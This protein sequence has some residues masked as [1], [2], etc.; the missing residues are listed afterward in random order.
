MRVLIY[1]INYSPELTG[2]GKYSGEMAEWLSSNGHEVVVV[3]APPYYPN[4]KVWDGYR[5]LGYSRELSS[6][7][8]S[9]MRC[10]LWVPSRPSGIKRVLH[11]LSFA[12]SS[13]PVVVR[14]ALKKPDIIFVVEPPLFCSL[15]AL[16]GGM[17]SRASTIL[18]IQDFEVDAAFEM[19]L[20]KGAAARRFALAVERFLLRRFDRVSTISNRMLELLREK[21]V[22]PEN[23]FIFPNWVDIGNIVPMARGG[24]SDYRAMLGIPVDSVVALYSGNMGGKQ[25]LEILAEAARVLK[26]VSSIYFVF[27]GNGAGR[28]DLERLSEGLPNV[29]FMDLQPLERLGELLTFADI[30]LLPQRAD[31]ADLVM[32]SKLTGMLASGRP[33]VATANVGTEVE[34]VVRGRGLVV[35]PGDAEAFSRAI[36]DL[37]ASA[38]SRET[39]GAAGRLYAEQHL[40]RDSVLKLV[41]SRFLG[42]IK[43]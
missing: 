3:T 31:A 28:G 41:V 35:P 25:G 9:V 22:L 15:G 13:F 29:R 37:S 20:L 39:L 26:D 38:T 5:A 4:W 17:L 7:G 10:P 32:P 23:S 33:V 11:L 16:V 6:S 36:L 42:L 1:G 12:F 21:G 14:E 19:G 24:C 2:I 43:T 40:D 34:S 18:H 27:C 8:V 30:H